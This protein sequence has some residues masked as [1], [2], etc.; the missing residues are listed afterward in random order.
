MFW[1]QPCQWNNLIKPEDGIALLFFRI[2][3][4]SLYLIERPSVH[5]D[6]DLLLLAR[7]TYSPR[8]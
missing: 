2:H 3:V 4:F 5:E 7:K 1:R 6:D 8:M